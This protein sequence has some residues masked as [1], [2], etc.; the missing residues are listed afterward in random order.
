MFYHANLLAIKFKNE[1]TALATFILLGFTILCQFN[2][3]VLGIGFLFNY[4]VWGEL[5]DGANMVQIIFFSIIFWLVLYFIFLYHKK[6]NAFI[7][8]FKGATEKQKMVGRYALVLYF[9]CSV[10]MFAIGC[11]IVHLMSPQIS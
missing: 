9:C 11:Y 3:V 4:D 2:F 7:E 10:L 8:E 5:V 6:W 1:D